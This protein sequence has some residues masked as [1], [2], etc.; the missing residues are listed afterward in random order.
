MELVKILERLTDAY[1]PSGQEQEVSQVI[2]EL[3]APY[4]DK[5][6]R[7]TMGNLICRKKGKGPKVMFSAHMDSIGLVATHID[8]HGYV[9][10]GAV[11]GISPAKVLHTPVR[12]ASGQGGVV[13]AQAGV[14]LSK[15]KISDL[16]IDVGASSRE[17]TEKLVQ[18]GDAA[19]FDTRLFQVSNRVSAPYLDNR[20]SCAVQLMV[21]SQLGQTDNDL[22]FV[23]SVQEEVGTR[24]AKTAA[25]DI[26]P[27]Y[28]IAL[29]VTPADDEP[30]SKHLVSSVLGGGAAVKVMDGSVICHPW[31]VEKLMTLAEEQGIR[32]QRDVIRAGGTDGGPIHLTRSG[33]PTGGISIPWRY[34]HSPMELVD[35]QDMQNCAALAKAFAECKLEKEC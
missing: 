27:D 14:E 24:G 23:F 17:E 3:A 20:A 25:W 33:V 19:V 9:R 16:F 11:G 30:G 31:M 1:G 29:D 35:L 22:Y 2:E 26:D 21:M 32:A 18:I 8:E 10:V 5:I 7:D 6:K 12:F 15:L 13:S 34:G 28:G 4:C